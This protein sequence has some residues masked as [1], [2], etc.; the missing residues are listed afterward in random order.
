MKISRFLIV[1]LIIVG[2]NFSFSFAQQQQQNALP[3]QCGDGVDNDKDGGIDVKG[4]TAPN[5]TVYPPDKECLDASAICEDGS[6][7]C[8]PPEVCGSG[9]CLK[10]KINNPLKVA[11]IQDAIK[12]FMDAVLKIALPFIVVFF[13]W[14]GL[15]FVLARGNPEKIKTAK[16]MFLY[17]II[18]TLLILGAWTI[19]NAIIG[20]VNSITG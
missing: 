18:G 5:N 9:F 16:N 4:L 19:T 20:T 12:L 14:S 2:L 13:I 17:T 8:T 7:S 15:S 1:A 6:K 3:T 10:V 11:T